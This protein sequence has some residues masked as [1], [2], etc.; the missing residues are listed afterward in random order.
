MKA[1]APSTA[2]TA[3]LDAEHV[4]Y[5]LVPHRRTQ[6][7]AAEA[8][9]IGLQPSHVAKT[10]ILATSDG[11]V[12]AVLPASERVDLRKVREALDDPVV[13]LASEAMLV[14]AYPEFEL[15]AVPPIGGSPDPVLVDRLVRAESEVVFEAGTHDHSVRVETERLLEVAHAHVAD[16]C[17]D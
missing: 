7:A 2:L 14:G 1:P 10:L 6:S 3:V 12:R 15:G 11:F 9:A 16:I 4:P 8:R 13:E 5:E 17:Q